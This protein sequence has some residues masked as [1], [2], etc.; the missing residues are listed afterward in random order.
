MAK[1]LRKKALPIIG[2][3]EWVSLPDLGL[4]NIKAKI[5]SGARSSA[6]HAFDLRAFTVGGVP[7]VRFRVH[8]MQHGGPTVEAE[9]EI[10]DMRRVRNPG[11]RREL[12]PVIRTHV[13]LSDKQ[14][15][16]DVTLTP[17]WGM[18]F[19]MLLGRQAI[20]RHFLVDPGGSFFGEWLQTERHPNKT[21]EEGPEGQ[22]SASK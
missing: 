10:T 2:W 18:S 17:R 7:W 19:R 13:E 14:W 1:V 20:R 8:P 3:R 12:R 5:D 22:Q 16:I 11:G 6:L 4:E 21:T 15:K 9:A